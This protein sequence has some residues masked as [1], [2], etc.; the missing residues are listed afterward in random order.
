[1]AAKRKMLALMLICGLL[2]SLVGC[3]GGT[4]GDKGTGDT[5][6]Q[7]SGATINIRYGH[8]YPT[9]SPAHAAATAFKTIVED[10]SGGTMK[11]E[12]YPAMQLGSNREQL[13]GVQQGSI[14]VVLQ[15][16]AIAGNFVP[17][18][19]VLDL[20]F[21]F[22]SEEVM[23][24]VLDGEYGQN[25][26]KKMEDK[27]IVG[28]GFAWTGFKQITSNKPITKFEDLKGL[29][30]RVM[31][32]PLLIKQYEAWGCNAIPIDFSELYTSLQQNVV[33]GQENN[34][35]TNATNR[36]YEVQTDFTVSAH[37][38][39]P[40]VLMC[41]KAWFD[42]LSPENQAII[43]EAGRQAVLT[44]R[45]ELRKTEQDAIA[46]IK[47]SGVNIHELSDEEIEKFKAAS[48]EIY[49]WARQE[50]GSEV[51]DGLMTA[52]EQAQ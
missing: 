36:Y 38:P 51:V 5:Q 28:L 35:W 9:D 40:A 50:L 19:Q 29:K 37:A 43:L 42:K 4:G 10:K 31:N 45:E 13:E 41:N 16:T 46:T 32:S 17:D 14:Q 27:G 52:V 12:I 47:A 1:M 34:F 21:V 44:D 22:P 20:P 24:R 11:V 18:F 3:G 48:Q 25:L 30:M 23:W 7:S 6:G 33:D 49:D 39:L 2:I 26:L 8:N 15:P